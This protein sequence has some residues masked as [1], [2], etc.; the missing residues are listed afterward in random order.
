MADFH[1]DC[2]E[3][4]QQSV[5]AEYERRIAEQGVLGLLSPY[6]WSETAGS[7][8]LQLGNEPEAEPEPALEPEPELPEST[9]SSDPVRPS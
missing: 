9:G 2:W 6:M 8:L 4:A 1:A 3:T 5:Q 7:D